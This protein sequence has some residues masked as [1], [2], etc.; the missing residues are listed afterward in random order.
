M[1][2]C[3]KRTSFPF[4]SWIRRIL[5]QISDHFNRLYFCNLIYIW[6]SEIIL[7]SLQQKKRSNHHQTPSGYSYSVLC[8]ALSAFRSCLSWGYL[9]FNN[10][11]CSIRIHKTVR[12]RSVF[13]WE[14]LPQN[15]SFVY[16]LLVYILQFLVQSGNVY[17]L[18]SLRMHAG[19]FIYDSR[20]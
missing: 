3:T 2:I 13:F 7:L 5:L 6:I 4:L 1:R 9:L 18:L 15:R 16:R 17:F 14:T 11:V 19:I 10:Y 8:K 20:R 12:S